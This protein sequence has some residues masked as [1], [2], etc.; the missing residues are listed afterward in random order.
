LK[1]V[2]AR[3]FFH[4]RVFFTPVGK[5][6][7]VTLVSIKEDEVVFEEFADGTKHLLGTIPSDAIRV[8][9]ILSAI[10]RDDLLGRASYA[11]PSMRDG[12]QVRVVTSLG[13]IT[14]YEIFDMDGKPQ[15]ELELPTHVT[16]LGPLVAYVND[17]WKNL[18]DKNTRD[19][20]G[21][22]NPQGGA[23]GR[24][25]SSSESNPTSPAAASRRSP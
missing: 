11:N 17:C 20:V 7:T 15:R 21:L 10:D 13:D 3:E 5:G 9:G 18:R 19:G 8:A 1:A 16:R 22:P 12:N 24:Q 14:L 6:K 2:A 4:A 25:P 23:N